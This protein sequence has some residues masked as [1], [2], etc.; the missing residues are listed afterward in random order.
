MHSQCVSVSV[1]VSIEGATYKQK[2]IALYPY[3]ECVGG[4][5]WRRKKR[6]LGSVTARYEGKNQYKEA[7]RKTTPSIAGTHSHTVHHDECNPNAA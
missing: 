5:E 6:P 1:G 2:Q 4:G 7:S 3:R